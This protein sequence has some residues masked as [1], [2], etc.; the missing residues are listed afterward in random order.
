VTVID[1]PT[2]Y[3]LLTVTPNPSVDRAPFAIRVDV[4]RRAVVAG[5]VR[6]A[7]PIVKYVRLPPGERRVMIEARAGRTFRPADAGSPDDRDLGLMMRWRFLPAEP[8]GGA[9]GVAR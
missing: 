6:D 5:D 4:D 7:R 9:A 1:A 8:G 2:P 3:L